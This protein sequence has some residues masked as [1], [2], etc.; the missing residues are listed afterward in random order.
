MANLQMMSVNSVPL[1]SLK[2]ANKER[3]EIVNKHNQVLRQ[4]EMNVSK[5]YMNND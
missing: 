1:A 2:A 5:V 3:E 4:L